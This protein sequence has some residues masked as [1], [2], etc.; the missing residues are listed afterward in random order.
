M[1]SAT[2][3]GSSRMEA[4]M[5]GS[6]PAIP[7]PAPLVFGGGGDTGLGPPCRIDMESNMRTRVLI[8]LSLLFFG[9]LAV[10]VENLAAGY[11]ALGTHAIIYLLH[12]MEVKLNRLLDYHNIFISDAEIARD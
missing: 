9:G 1:I 8:G 12:A 7:R 6:L 3:L 2:T 10:H 5:F 11:V 4:E